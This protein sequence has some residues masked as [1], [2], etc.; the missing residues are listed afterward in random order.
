M[1]VQCDEP[2]EVP[3]DPVVCLKVRKQQC[4]QGILQTTAQDTA[5]E[6]FMGVPFAKPPVGELR[7]AVGFN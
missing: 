2:E 3:R 4:M 7:F 6:A 5:F 1:M